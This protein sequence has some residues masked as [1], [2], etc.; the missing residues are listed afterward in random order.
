[1][2]ALDLLLGI[3]VG[4]YGLKAALWRADGT[5]V[6]LCRREYGVHHPHPLWAEQDPT[7]WWHALKATVTEAVGTAGVE[8]SCI[9]G[10]G[11]SAFIPPLVPVDKRGAV[12]RPAILSFDQRSV[13]QA[14]RL[15]REVG[16]EVFTVAG[17]R[18]AP[19]AF[20]ATSM[21]WIKEQE[22]QVFEAAHKFVH[23]NGYLVYRLTGHFS[24]DF[25]NAS[26]TLLFDPA[27]RRWSEA[28]CD[29]I[30][31]PLEKLPAAVG[32]WDVVGELTSDAADDLGLPRGIPVVAGGNDSACS[33]LG[34]GVVEP[35]MVLESIGTSIVFAYVTDRP[36]FD[37]R[38]MNRCHVVPDRWF[39]LAGMS[40]P[41]AAYRWFRDELGAGGTAVAAQL[42]TDPYAL[43]DADAAGA[44]P[45][46]RGLMFL[47]YLS[48]ERSPIWNPNARGV[49]FGL[50]LNH[51]RGDVLRSILEGGAYAVRDN[52]DVFT[53]RGLAIQGIRITGGGARS[54]LWRQIMADV[55]G[56]P[57][58]R[59]ATVETATLGAAILAGCGAGVYE[60]P[61]SA[62]HRLVRVED[63]ET[64]RAKE[65]A[66]YGQY[67]ELFK[68]I[69]DRLLDCYELARH[70][71]DV[72]V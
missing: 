41:G 21:I 54:Q 62:A 29:L 1:V 25:S 49:I 50:T 66:L 39:N 65:H 15:S 63:A 13:L 19:G 31:V 64:P 12:L 8:P 61:R 70:L 23:A 24:M 9:L 33:M 18:I 2:T 3:D 52:M 11:V 71:E 67:F 17:N 40:T 28:L 55:L 32:A 53:T 51:T 14:A 6:T 43:L 57:L 69:Y 10:I 27:E 46:A 72:S 34:A 48:G 20:S 59:P 44:P 7:T 5:L 56:V 45:G 58:T 60:S 16:R 42:K 26:M 30:G 68:M 36:V 35:G 22:P 38:L 47:P 4:T 37:A